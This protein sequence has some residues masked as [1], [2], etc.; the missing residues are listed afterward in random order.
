MLFLVLSILLFQ[1]DLIYYLTS[2]LCSSFKSSILKLSLSPNK[3][4]LFV[5]FLL[6]ALRAI[7]FETICASFILATTV[8]D[9]NLTVLHVKFLTI[10]CTHD[11]PGCKTEL[12]LAAT[13]PSLFT[14]ALSI[15][16]YIYSLFIILDLAHSWNMSGF[17]RFQS[18]IFCDSKPSPWNSF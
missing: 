15:I 2:H 5:A 13:T 11:D 3:F 14:F 4:G 10:I 8:F 9:F 7:I 6:L 17:E 12:V 1:T 18:N 16:I